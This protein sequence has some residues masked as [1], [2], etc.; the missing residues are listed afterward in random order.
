[1]KRKVTLD[2]FYNGNSELTRHKGRGDI[3]LLQNPGH[4]NVFSRANL[5]HRIIPYNRRDFYK[6]SLIV[7]TGIIN[8][9]DKS[10]E[11]NKNALL[12]SNP[13]IPYSWE[14]T[15][16]KQ[17]GYFCLFTQEFFNHGR[18]VNLNEL[19]FFKP[20][21]NEPVYFVDE[22][23]T[24]AISAI[25]ENM[26]KEISSD[27]MY[28]FE[29][30]GTYLDLIIHEALKLKP[31][32]SYVKHRDASTRITSLFLELL[33]R[34]FPVDSP[35]NRLNLKTANEFAHNLSVHVNHL[36]RAV[37]KITGKT[38]TQLISSRIAREARAL[39]MN[40]DWNISEISYVLGFE[41][42]TYFNSFFKKQTGLTPKSLRP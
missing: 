38:T 2:E 11:I 15:S 31:A 9:A 41:Y 28:K 24:A 35:E 21:A 20:G 26:L 39:L 30:L 7:G 37:K 14:A 40:T 17:E 27:Y 36:N 42:P 16:E 29:L 19:P 23:Q 33:E 3:P 34:Q 6:V 1:M 12:F 10:I 8:Y 13:Y 25:Y 4:F 32:D 5:C 18:N 22:A